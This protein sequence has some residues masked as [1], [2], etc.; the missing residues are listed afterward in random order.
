MT[1]NSRHRTEKI[2]AKKETETW[3]IK[4]HEDENLV[5]SNE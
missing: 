5:L 3:K 1:L 4:T 2:K